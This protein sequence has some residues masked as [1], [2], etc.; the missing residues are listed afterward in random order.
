MMVKVRGSS[1]V[2]EVPTNTQVQVSVY[3]WKWPKQN[4]HLYESYGPS[5]WKDGKL[6][7]VKARE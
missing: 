7:S 4:W 3:V 2:M 1:W 6:A 5:E